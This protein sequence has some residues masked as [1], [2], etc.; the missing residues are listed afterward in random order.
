MVTASPAA[1]PW[2]NSCL[3]PDQVMLQQ[4]GWAP[5]CAPAPLEMVVSS[6]A[7]S[8]SASSVTTAAATGGLAGERNT[9]YPTTPRTSTSTAAPITTGSHGNFFFSCAAMSKVTRPESRALSSGA[10]SA[11]EARPYSSYRPGGVPGGTTARTRNEAKPL[12]PGMRRCGSSTVNQDCC[13]PGPGT[14]ANTAMSV[15][16]PGLL[17]VK[18]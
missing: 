14:T 17:T 6:C 18:V 2:K 12:R 5:S 11:D 16:V 13:A 15:A 7:A 10:V 1:W 4:F 9:R 8:V 3:P